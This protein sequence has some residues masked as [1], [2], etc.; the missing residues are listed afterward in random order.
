ME[1]INRNQL[2]KSIENRITVLIE[3]KRNLI[4]VGP[5]GLLTQVWSNTVLEHEILKE[6][7][8]KLQGIFIQEDEIDIS[9]DE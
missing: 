3:R 4:P 2:I 7:S 5:D 1:I 9:D 8:T 6:T